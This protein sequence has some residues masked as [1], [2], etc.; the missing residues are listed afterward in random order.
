M[1]HLRFKVIG[2]QFVMCLGSSCLGMNLMRPY[3]M[4]AL[5]DCFFICKGLHWKLSNLQVCRKIGNITML[6]NSLGKK[7][8]CKIWWNQRWLVNSARPKNWQAINLSM[9]MSKHH[10][11]RRLTYSW[12]SR[13]VPNPCL[14]PNPFV[15]HV[16]MV[17]NCTH[18]ITLSSICILIFSLCN[19]P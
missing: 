18:N 16:S 14:V 9:T 12:S 8:T 6:E 17:G 19:C 13:L 1:K 2:L 11:P 4:L 15:Q 3:L 10:W 5:R 7:L